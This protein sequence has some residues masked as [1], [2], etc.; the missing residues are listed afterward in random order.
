MYSWTALITSQFIV[1]LP[2]NIFSSS[3]FF[4]CWYFAVDFPMSRAGYTYLMMGV[5]LPLYYT[6]IGQAM[7]AM[8]ATV[9]IAA[10]LFTSMFSFVLIL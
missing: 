9:E 6:S 10:L 2:Y 5:L 4:L 3:V 7:A 8:A 1:E